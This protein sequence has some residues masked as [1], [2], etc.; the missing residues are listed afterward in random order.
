MTLNN[1][2]RKLFTSEQ[3]LGTKD[4]VDLSEK[5]GV[6]LGEEPKKSLPTVMIKKTAVLPVL[7]TK[8]KI[9]KKKS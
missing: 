3:K 4:K 1:I 2:L 7:A 6:E 5:S 9:E 8:M